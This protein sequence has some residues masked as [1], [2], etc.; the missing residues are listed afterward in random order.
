MQNTSISLVS[1]TISI[2]GQNINKKNMNQQLIPT[3][4]GTSSSPQDVNELFTANNHRKSQ[5]SQMTVS[6]AHQDKESLSMMIAKRNGV[7]P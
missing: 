4:Y 1:K 6:N 2:Q 7:N 3:E 5:Q